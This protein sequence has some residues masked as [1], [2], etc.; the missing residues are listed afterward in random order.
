MSFRVIIVYY[1]Y[2]SIIYNIRMYIYEDKWIKIFIL[3]GTYN[4]IVK[5]IDKKHGKY[6]SLHK[7]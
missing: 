6:Q 3:K 1:K 2:I 7:K 5:T 4:K